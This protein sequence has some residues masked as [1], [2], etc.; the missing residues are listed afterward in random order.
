MAKFVDY[1]GV[2]MKKLIEE[3]GCGKFT[4]A[5]LKRKEIEILRTV[6]F[7][8]EVVT[9][10]DILELL[11]ADFLCTHYNGFKKIEEAKSLKKIKNWCIYLAVL[12]C[13]NYNMLRFE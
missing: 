2:K 12:S 8:P 6:G 4:E 13:Y 3:M 9:G 10:Y 1:N 11:F 7:D 5:E